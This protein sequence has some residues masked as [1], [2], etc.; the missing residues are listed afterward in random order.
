[1]NRIQFT[2]P[3]R[4]LFLDVSSYHLGVGP[5]Q[6]WRRAYLVIAYSKDILFAL[7]NLAQKSA[8]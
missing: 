2:C 3:K 8:N 7:E 5:I 1:M 6:S 4:S